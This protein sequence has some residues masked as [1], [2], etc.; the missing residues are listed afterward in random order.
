MKKFYVECPNCGHDISVEPA[1]HDRQ[2]RTEILLDFS[3]RLMEYNII[4]E[5][6]IIDELCFFVD[7][8]EMESLL[9]ENK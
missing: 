7:R 2:I 1:E 6:D 5:E 4:T 9:K 8:N 3:K